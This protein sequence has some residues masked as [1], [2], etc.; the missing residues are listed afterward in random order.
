MSLSTKLRS[1]RLILLQQFDN[2]LMCRL[3]GTPRRNVI[4]SVILVIQF[5]RNKDVSKARQLALDQLV[6]YYGWVMPFGSGA[7]W[8]M[9]RPAKIG[10]VRRYAKLWLLATGELPTGIHEV[11]WG[12]NAGWN[13]GCGYSSEVNFDLLQ[14]SFLP[15]GFSGPPAPPVRCDF[16]GG[17]VAAR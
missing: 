14:P 16:K 2:K 17:K 7:A 15:H 3:C 6:A 5:L 9:G 1:T 13:N 4:I 12:Q 10:G 8:T 11:P